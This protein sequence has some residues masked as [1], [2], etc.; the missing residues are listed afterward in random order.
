MKIEYRADGSPMPIL[1]V[2]D[3]VRLVRNEGGSSPSAQAEEWGRILRISRG[4]ALDIVLAGYS[5]PR[6]V[7]LSNVNGIPATNVVPCDHRGVALE[8]PKFA[9]W[10]NVNASS[11]NSRKTRR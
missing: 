10:R 4:G 11:F 1:E 6:G 9:N 7:A 2:G 8:L 3:L 5:R